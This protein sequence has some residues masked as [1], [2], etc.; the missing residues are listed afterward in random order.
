MLLL[1]R[2]KEFYKDVKETCLLA[3]LAKRSFR[4]KFRGENYTR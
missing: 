4:K 2:F 3:A 1:N